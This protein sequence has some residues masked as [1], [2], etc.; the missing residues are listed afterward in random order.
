MEG[1]NRWVSWQVPSDQHVVW[2]CS[3]HHW[4]GLLQMSVAFFHLPFGGLKPLF[5]ENLSYNLQI[6]FS[7]FK[8]LSSSYEGLQPHP[9]VLF[10]SL[11]PW[12]LTLRCVRGINYIAGRR[13]PVTQS[14]Q[15]TGP[16]CVLVPH[17]PILRGAEFRKGHPLEGGRKCKALTSIHRHHGF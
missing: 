3:S 8:F 4:F 5:Y 7:V 13:S 9:S 15:T 2:A 14:L 1:E 16:R 6:C 10:C 12:H 11:W 17:W